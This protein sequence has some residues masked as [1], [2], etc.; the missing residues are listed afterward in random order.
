MN[1]KLLQYQN[2]YLNVCVRDICTLFIIRPYIT[3]ITLPI[4][5]YFVCIS[6]C[7]SFYCVLCFSV[8]LTFCQPKRLWLPSQQ[9]HKQEC[10][11]IW[12]NDKRML[13]AATALSFCLC[14][15]VYL[16]FYVFLWL[17]TEF[18]IL[19]QHVNKQVLNWSELNRNIILTS[20]STLEWTGRIPDIIQVSI[21]YFAYHKT[22]LK[23]NT[24]YIQTES[25]WLWVYN[26]TICFERVWSLA[27]YCQ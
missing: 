10:K 12:W 19:S 20:K 5:V 24:L 15:F 16:S 18:V 9:V 25:R 2:S 4:F 7:I 8:L 1:K 17:L 27:S 26:F 11:V 13:R 23:I 3:I 22:T 14:F 21:L 6:I